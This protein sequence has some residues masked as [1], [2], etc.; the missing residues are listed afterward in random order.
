MSLPL[1]EVEIDA[2]QYDDE[3]GEVVCISSCESNDCLYDIYACI[4]KKGGF[5]GKL[6]KIDMK[7]KMVH[8]GEVH[9][10]RVMPQNHVSS[11]GINIALHILQEFLH[12]C[13]LLVRRRNEISE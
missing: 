12:V 2:R 11:A 1:P 5:G 3:K 9:R 6:S 4:R 13:G 7:I 10:A 8:D